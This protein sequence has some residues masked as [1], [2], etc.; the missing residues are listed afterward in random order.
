MTKGKREKPLSHGLDFHE[1]LRRIV[2]TKPGQI[3]EILAR[4]LS[5]SMEE[6]TA[7]IGKQE[8]K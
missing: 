3:A 6:T 2:Q 4:D 5:R 1:A 7:R 8:R